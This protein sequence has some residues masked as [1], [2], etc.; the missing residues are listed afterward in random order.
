MSGPLA[1][2]RVIEFAGLGPGPFCGMMLADHGAE[3]IRIDRKNPEG[4]LS[5]AAGEVWNRSRKN[6]AIDLK[7]ADGIALVRKL[8]ASADALIEGFRPGVMERLGLGPDVLLADNPKL[9]YGRMTGWGQDGPYAA[10]A[11]HDINY[12]ALSGALHAI[13]RKDERPVPPLNLVGDFGG[14]G[15][16]LAFGVLAAILNA[17]RTGQGQVVDC[18]MTEGSAALM[19]IMYSMLAQ[20]RWRD[21]R[22]V[23][24]LDSGAHF[25]DTYET[26]DGK[27]MSVGAIEPQ[28]YRKFL[29][30]LGLADDPEFAAQN[31]Q[32][33]W[34]TLKQKI[35]AQFKT[36]TRA[37][38]EAIFDGEDACVTPV[39]SLR[40]APQHPHNKARDAFVDIAG[41]RQPAPAPR[42]SATPSPTPQP[43]KQAVEDILSSLPL[44]AAE[45]QV[46]IRDGVVA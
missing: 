2:L 7:S 16:F 1:G 25:Y 5:N 24:L 26:K 30:G 20:G 45:V 46:L 37:E 10:M 15:M 8:C 33:R 21:E 42:Y 6:I 9:V 12:I 18:A 40:E 3:V 31:D 27:F 23:N 13:G 34:S 14:G 36:K 22:G 35:I 39:L 44:S 11:G 4:L 43:L 38:W 19:V 29:A 28:F 41:V 32:S 17:R